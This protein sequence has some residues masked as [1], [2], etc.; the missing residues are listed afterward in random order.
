MGQ[1]L[2]EPGRGFGEVQRE[3]EC[4]HV[5]EFSPRPMRGHRRLAGFLE[6]GHDSGGHCE[7]GVILRERNVKLRMNQRWVFGFY[8]TAL[9]AFC[10]L[11]R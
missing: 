3:A 10:Q 8:V 6:P 4:R 2:E 7:M 5:H 1:V 11:R 9:F